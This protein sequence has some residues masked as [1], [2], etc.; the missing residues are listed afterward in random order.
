MQHEPKKPLEELAAE[1]THGE[2]R[3]HAFHCTPSS[4]SFKSINRFLV[5]N[6]FSAIAI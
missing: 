6:C 5:Q 1:A 3:T 2:A 4:Q